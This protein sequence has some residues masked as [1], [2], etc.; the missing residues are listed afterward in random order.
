MDSSEKEREEI[1][2]G[3]KFRSHGLRQQRVRTLLLLREESI[4]ADGEIGAARIVDRTDG[5]DSKNIEDDF[6]NFADRA[7]AT[8]TKEEFLQPF[9]STG[10]PQKLTKSSVP[11]YRVIIHEEDNQEI[12][13]EI[14]AGAASKFAKIIV[15]RELHS[16]LSDRS[17]MHVELNVS[18]T[19]LTY[20]TGDHVAIYPENDPEIVKQAATCLGLPLSTVFTLEM[21]KNNTDG[22]EKLFDDPITLKAALTKYADL[23]THLTSSPCNTCPLSRRT[24]RKLKSC[25]C[26][27]PTK[28]RINS[29]RWS[30]TT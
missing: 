28:E 9:A 19:G 27:R 8:L 18:E 17:C 29:P 4:P 24:A 23:T 13:A 25:Y 6:D 14:P 16:E 22:L 10:A 12:K 7:I 11:A 3:V 1:L 26:S 5:D 15:S 21:P 20:E 30:R 2:D